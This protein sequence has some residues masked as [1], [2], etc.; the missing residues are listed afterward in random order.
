ALGAE[1][2]LTAGGVTR[3]EIV[4]FMDGF[5]TQ[6]PLELHMGLGA[7]SVIQRLEVSWPSGA[8][9][10]WHDLPVD[11]RLVVREGQSEVAAAPLAAWPA[12]TAPRGTRP[13]LDV[14]LDTPQGGSQALAAPGKPTY[15]RC[16]AS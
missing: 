16:C 13:R 8:K 10:E 1:V 14:F 7:S 6:V 11:Q 2:R 4:R 3:R 15:N 12:P 9:E 5:Q